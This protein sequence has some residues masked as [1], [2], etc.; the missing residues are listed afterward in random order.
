MPDQQSTGVFLN[1]TA[2]LAPLYRGR[3]HVLGGSVPPARSTKKT[4]PHA[5]TCR[6][7]TYN[8][9][10][11]TQLYSPAEDRATP[12]SRIKS[13]TSRRAGGR[14]LACRLRS[15]MLHRLPR[16]GGDMSAP[17]GASV[18]DLD[19]RRPAKTICAACGIPFAPRARSHDRCSSCYAWAAVA[20]H[21]GRA[22]AALRAIR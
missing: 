13:A 22:A 21:A 16:A 7:G 12:P 9:L 6:P 19:S 10:L 11:G 3:T 2:E 17:Q 8:A 1:A 15:E 14:H 20:H 18:I 4:G 5:R